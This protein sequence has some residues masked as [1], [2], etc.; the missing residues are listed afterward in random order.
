MWPI[1]GRLYLGP[2]KQ[3][4]AYNG[5]ETVI[6]RCRKSLRNSNG[7]TQRGLQIEVE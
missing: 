2:R 5:P 7:G 3:R 4:V 6:F 1:D